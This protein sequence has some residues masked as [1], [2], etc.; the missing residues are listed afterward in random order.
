MP[1]EAPEFSNS[2]AGALCMLA[3]A[4]WARDFESHMVLAAGAYDACCNGFLNVEVT[5]AA[6]KEIINAIKE[7]AKRG[8]K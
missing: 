8:K 7:A 5:D 4:P 1:P 6:R 2:V 3:V